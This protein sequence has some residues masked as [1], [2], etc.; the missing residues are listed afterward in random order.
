MVFLCF[1]NLFCLLAFVIISLYINIMRGDNISDTLV[2]YTGICI[3]GTLI[4]SGLAL[5]AITGV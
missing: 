2:I 5:L 3:L 4:T 1:A